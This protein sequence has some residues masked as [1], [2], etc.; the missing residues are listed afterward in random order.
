V[1]LASRLSGCERSW[2]VQFV[3]ALDGGFRS[4]VFAGTTAG[5]DDVVIKLAAT[6]QEVEAEAAALTMWAHSGAAVRLLGV[7]TE[8]CALL[9][10]RVKPASPLPCGDDQTAV[11]VAVS[12]LSRLH[13]VPIGTFPFPSLIQSY[14]QHEHRAREDAT[15][16]QR[17][18][19]DPTRGLA[20]LER[21]DAARAAATELCATTDRPVVLH[22]DFLDKNL[23]WDGARYLAIDPIPSI[24]DPCSDVGFFAACRPPAKHILRRADAIAAQMGLSPERTQRWAA[25]WTVLQACQ[26]WRQDQSDLDSCVASAQFERLL[27]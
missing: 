24:G 7:D 10:E 17:A 2:R 18:S 12:L 25:I 11:D 13:K 3:D 20:G 4:R 8:H 21:L 16:E 6:V 19:G 5:G 9:L 26:A 23:L 1:D 15:Y 14:L 27:V 22:G